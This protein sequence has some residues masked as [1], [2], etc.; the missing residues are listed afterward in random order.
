MASSKV[1]SINLNTYSFIYRLIDLLVLFGCM[2]LAIEFYGLTWEQEYI[3][4]PLVVSVCF[5]YVAESFGLYRSW[6]VGHFSEMLLSFAV[7]ITLSFFIALMLAFLLKQSEY[8]PRNLILLWFL[9]SSLLSVLWRFLLRQYIKASH[10][11]GL[12]IKRLVMIGATSSGNNFLEEVRNRDELGYQIVG[13]YDDRQPDRVFGDLHSEVAGKIEEAVTLARNGQIDMVFIALPLKAEKRIADILVRLG[14]TTVDVHYIPDFLIS[15]LVRSRLANVG[16]ID[17]LSV[18]ESPYLG[19]REW[20]K[21]TED[22]IISCIILCLILVPLLIIAIAIKLTSPG[23]ILFKQRRYGLHGEEIMVWKFRTMNVL[24]NNDK[25]VQATKGDSRVTKFGNF[26]RRTSL[27]EFPQFFNVLTGSMS[28]VGPRPHAVAHNEEYRS[29]VRFYMLRHKVKP[30]VTG[31]AQINGWRGETD[32]LDKME[33]RV[34]F[35]LHYIKNWS[36]WLDLKIIFLTIF[37]GFTNPNAY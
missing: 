16:D 15:S 25:V 21:R 11:A 9:L 22:I 26:L 27:D 33:N 29:K 3:V 37:K 31:W 12:N 5:L 6:R 17:V 20:I 7:C 30:G 35:D 8:F 13:V 32:T 4:G 24:E 14:D 34:K 2:G 10:K 28:I 23:P 18:F 36:L 1:F 19:A